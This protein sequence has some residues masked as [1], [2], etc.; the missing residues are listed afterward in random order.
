[1]AYSNYGATVYRDGKPMHENCDVTI[2]QV[3][4]EEDRYKNYLMHFIRK[5]EDLDFTD[6]MYH[7]VVGDGNSGVMVGLYKSYPCV[8]KMSD[9][10]LKKVDFE[11]ELEDED[12]FNAIIEEGKDHKELVVNNIIVKLTKIDKPDGIKCEFTDKEGHQW[13]SK[14]AYCY[15]EGHEEWE[16]SNEIM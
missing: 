6:K 2:K 8:F 1:M 11:F 4:G 10:G 12:I 13:T 7:A 3:L 5:Q 14:S 16:D 9:R 15:G